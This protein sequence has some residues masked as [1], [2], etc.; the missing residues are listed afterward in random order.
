MLRDERTPTDRHTL[1][2]ERRGDGLRIDGWELGEICARVH[3]DREYEW[4]I[5]VAAA[6]VPALVAALGGAPDEDA[7]AVIARACTAAPD[8]LV[9]ALHAHAIPHAFGMRLGD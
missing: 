2:V 8:R 6:D 7:L 4:A 9:A 3:G 1:T 5:D